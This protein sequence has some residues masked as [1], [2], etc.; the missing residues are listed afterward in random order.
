MLISLS[1]VRFPATESG[2]QPCRTN[3]P[4]P[5]L[6]F[7]RGSS[8]QM[9]STFIFAT[10]FVGLLI[11]SIVL[12]GLFLR[13]GLRWAKVPNVTS[14]R[15]ILVTGLVILLNISLNGVLMLISPSSDVQ[16]LLVG[17]AEL[18]AA[19]MVPCIVIS[20]VFKVRF[21]RAF[22]AWLPTNLG[23]ITTVAIVLLVLRPLL[24]ESFLVPT[25]GMAPTLLGLHRTG[26]CPECGEPSYGSPQDEKDGAIA[27]SQ[28]ICKNFHTSGG[29]EM[30]ERVHQGDRF[31][32]AKFL[33]PRRWDL[34]VFQYPGDPANLFVKRL[35]GLP[36][37]TIHLQEGRVWV[38]GHRQTPPDSLAGIEYLSEFPNRFGQE[39]W[40]TINRP[41]VLGENEYFVLGDFSVQSLDSRW[42]QE[43]APGRNPYVV[44]Q[45]H[46]RGVVTHTFWPIHRWRIHR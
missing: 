36:G 46:L 34:V 18:A 45:S 4:K 6:Y 25:N 39:L 42:W 28:M 19:V 23:P 11:A 26:I 35:V 12:W 38:N 13:L 44:P 17:L 8:N 10:L 9:F 41:A 16:A 1:V 33:K 24:Y 31:L 40:G 29:L 15:V 20:V 37:E 30:D 21:L 14:R 2:F 22:L 5:I 3:R 32:A 27:P 43:G 7:S